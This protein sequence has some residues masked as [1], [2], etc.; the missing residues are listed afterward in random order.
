[1]GNF[2][3]CVCLCV[4][5]RERWTV[6]ER[7]RGQKKAE[8]K[9]REG[10]R[11][12]TCLSVKAGNCPMCQPIVYQRGGSTYSSYYSLPAASVCLSLIPSSGTSASA[13]QCFSITQTHTCT[14][15]HF[16]SS[17]TM[18]LRPQRPIR[19][20]RRGDTVFA[21]ACQTDSTS[22]ASQAP[23]TPIISCLPNQLCGET[24]GAMGLKVQERMWG[25]EDVVKRGKQRGGQ[26]EAR[27]QGERNMKET[28]LIQA[29]SLSALKP[30]NHWDTVAPPWSWEMTEHIQYI[31]NLKKASLCTNKT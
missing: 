1:M 26:R 8:K 25:Y 18:N 12:M 3:L 14:P 2:Y 24:E 21:R 10:E 20:R 5:Y 31:R 19:R 9:Q 16:A 13:H 23:N 29:H 17:T 22:P 30:Q 28:C 4:F 27:K 11:Q 6:E 7:K 15:M